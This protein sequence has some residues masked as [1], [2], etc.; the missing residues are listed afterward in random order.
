MTA[1][2]KC[3]ALPLEPAVDAPRTESVYT[4]RKPESRDLP[5]RWPWTGRPY[6]LG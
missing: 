1:A 6:G 2:R 3:P 4:C 5:E